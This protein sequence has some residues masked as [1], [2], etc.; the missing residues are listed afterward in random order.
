MVFNAGEINLLPV[1]AGG[2]KGAVLDLVV[3]C[4]LSRLC[5]S[6]LTG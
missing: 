4:Q 3:G 6:N 2:L 1:P 5:L